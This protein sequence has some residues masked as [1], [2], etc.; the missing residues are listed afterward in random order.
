MSDQ[1]G[2][3]PTPPPAAAPSESTD[4][5]GAYWTVINDLTKR[6]KSVT[7]LIGAI[8]L[9]LGFTYGAYEF[10]FKRAVDGAA[11][12][13]ILLLLAGEENAAFVEGLDNETRQRANLL[14]IALESQQLRKMRAQVDSVHSFN[15]HRSFA[16]P[17]PEFDPTDPNTAALAPDSVSGVQ[18]VFVSEDQ[19]L[20][21]YVYP[22]IRNLS[23]GGR[24][25]HY[26]DARFAIRVGSSAETIPLGTDLRVN[27]RSITCLAR[28]H[29]RTRPGENLL[30]IQVEF[31][32]NSPVIEYDFD[33]VII[34]SKDQDEDA[35]ACA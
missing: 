20:R 22:N 29:L 11:R 4:R 1:T 9:I 28:A 2:Q 3:S 31:E 12:E 17:L 16:G 19:S 15:L 14:E 27:G 25:Y 35:N 13:K 30:S 34:S 6:L 21:L 26:S 18:K 23:A 7:G 8:A 33:V 10:L 5:S 24:A 32:G